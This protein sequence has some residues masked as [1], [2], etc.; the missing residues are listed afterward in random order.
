MWKS[1][2]LFAVFSFCFLLPLSYASANQVWGMRSAITP[3]FATSAF[4]PESLCDGS[5]GSICGDCFNTVF[6]LGRNGNHK[7]TQCDNERK[8]CNKELNMCV[9]DPPANQSDCLTGPTTN[10]NCMGTGFFPHPTNCSIFYECLDSGVAFENTCPP[11]YSWTGHE[12]ACQQ[13]LTTKDCGTVNCRPYPDTFQLLSTNS[14]YY[15]YCDFIVNGQQEV[16]MFKCQRENEVF[17][18]AKLTCEFACPEEKLYADPDNN[19][20]YYHCYKSGANLVYQYKQC[21]GGR[22]FSEPDQNCKFA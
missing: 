17:N 15:A 2:I 16:L 12:M 11:G 9:T 1:S 21:T 18:L 13:K 14:A 7:V 20:Y 3:I 22:V 5:Y 8:Y 19:S 4:D 10:F 6:C